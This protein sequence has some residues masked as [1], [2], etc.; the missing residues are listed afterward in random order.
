MKVSSLVA[1]ILT[2]FVA[3]V[4]AVPLVSRATDD[5]NP[6][7]GKTFYGN[8]YYQSMVENEVSRFK[9]EGNVDLAAKAAKVARVPVFSWIYDT[10]SVSDITGYLED[11]AA[12]QKKTGKKQIVQLVIYNLPD[13]DC[14]SKASAG[15]LS[16]TSSAAG[17]TP[18]QK[19]L[20]SAK[21]QIEK[22]PDVAVALILEPDSIGDLVASNEVSKCKN[23]AQAHKRLL[24]LAI[25]TLQI[26]NVSIYLDGANAG[27]LGSPETLAPTAA[28]LAEILK[29]ART[30][31]A[32]ATVRGLA[33]NV[34]NY[35][36]LGNQKEAGKD[37]LKYINDLA[38]YLKKVGF[39]AN[40]IV[41][42][43]RAGNQKASRGDDSWCNFKY[44]GFGLRPAVT[45]HPLVD[46]VVWVKPGGESDGTT[47]I[48]SSRYDTTCIS[49]TSYIPSPEAG[50][51]SSAIFR[52]LL[53]QANPAF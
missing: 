46:A 24:S 2:A 19:L 5:S 18:Y 40:F 53:E 36:G 4:S 25:A 13:R 43:G 35:N 15:E 49:P 26:P 9:A 12:I 37:E 47:E 30:Y 20:E 52:L 50:D 33:T 38:P 21:A 48:S 1:A 42:Q 23:S 34:S 28:L 11:A 31:H 32:N 16:L 39:P 14:S 51:W 44:A 27:W 8:P 17:E 6:F 41:D 3:S 29:D 45:T 10:S 22:Y 7:A